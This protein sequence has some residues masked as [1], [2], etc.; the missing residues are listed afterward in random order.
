M[1]LITFQNLFQVQPQFT[2][3]FVKEIKCPEKYESLKQIEYIP[4]KFDEIV[5]LYKISLRNSINIIGL[6]N[7][8]FIDKKKIKT[9]QQSTLI[10]KLAIEGGIPLLIQSDDMNTD[11]QIM[12]ETLQ[13]RIT[14]QHVLLLE[15][16][17]QDAFKIT[18][19]FGSKIV[20]C[21]DEPYLYDKDSLEIQIDMFIPDPSQKQVVFNILVKLRGCPSS[22]INEF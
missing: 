8:L 13:T 16:V 1:S 5:R 17:A 14:K 10:Q 2:E 15:N 21:K 3:T 19:M 7:N 6:V 18:N 9:K 12:Y 4:S 11:D 20:M 22:Q